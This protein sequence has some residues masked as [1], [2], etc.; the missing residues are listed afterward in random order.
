MRRGGGGGG[1]FILHLRKEERYGWTTPELDARWC[2]SQPI[3]HA[4]N[5][6]SVPIHTPGLKGNVETNSIT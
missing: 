4:L 2:A 1:C 5:N 3:C 6:Q